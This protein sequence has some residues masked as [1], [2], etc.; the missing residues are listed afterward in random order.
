MDIREIILI[1]KTIMNFIG[2]NLLDVYCH[3]MKLKL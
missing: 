3:Y 1:F 2:L